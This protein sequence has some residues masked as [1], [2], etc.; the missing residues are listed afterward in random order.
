MMV[1][2]GLGSPSQCEGPDRLLMSPWGR[3]PRIGCANS[4][5]YERRPVASSTP[6]SARTGPFIGSGLVPVRG[7]VSVRL[8]G[9]DP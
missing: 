7:P 4:L 1:N 3:E 2:R 5:I 6:L 9:A 8:A